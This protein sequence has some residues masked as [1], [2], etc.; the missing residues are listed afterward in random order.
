MKTRSDFLRLLNGS[1]VAGNTVA[2]AKFRPQFRVN[3]NDLDDKE[4][5]SLKS[6][7]ELF[8][9]GYA[10]FDGQILFPLQK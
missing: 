5:E 9:G 3:L 1:I 2:L 6:A 8:S 10:D 4:F 7:N